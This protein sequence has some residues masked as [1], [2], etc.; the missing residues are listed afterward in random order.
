MTCWLK[1]APLGIGDLGVDLVQVES[2]VAVTAIV[3]EISGLDEEAGNGVALERDVEAIVDPGDQIPLVPNGGSAHLGVTP[4]TLAHRRD[5]RIDAGREGIAEPLLRDSFQVRR[6]RRVGAE[7]R[8]RCAAQHVAIALQDT[9]GVISRKARSQRTPVVQANRNAGARQQD[10]L[11]RV[12]HAAIVLVGKHPGAVELVRAIHQRERLR[13]H[14]RLA[15]SLELG[16]RVGDVQAARVPVGLERRFPVGAAT[17]EEGALVFVA[18]AQVERDVPAQLP[19]VLNERAVVVGGVFLERHV[20]SPGVARV[21]RAEQEARPGIAAQPG[22]GIDEGVGGLIVAERE[23]ERLRADG[24]D[25]HGAELDAELEEMTS[26]LTRELRGVI[27]RLRVLE[28]PVRFAVPPP[29]LP[30][31]IR[32]PGIVERR[33][34]VQIPGVEIARVREE[35]LVVVESGVLLRS[36]VVVVVGDVVAANVE[37]RPRVDRPDQVAGHV[38]RVHRAAVGIGKKPRMVR[39]EVQSSIFVRNRLKRKNDRRLSAMTKSVRLLML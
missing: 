31:L 5:D 13:R 14:L 19:V 24:I 39:G 8:N 35:L 25:A 21:H 2:I 6:E 27:E 36:I 15:R 12:P 26:C 7:A 22:V 37:H 18:Q 30:P 32:M 9:R 29:G 16:N 34:E 10:E 20:A 1:A 11:A 28:P 17:V 38:Q 33:A 23:P 3:E 4:V